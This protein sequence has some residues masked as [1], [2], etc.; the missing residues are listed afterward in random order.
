MAC[1]FRVNVNQVLILED[2]ST[3]VIQIA[4]KWK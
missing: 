3:M 2:F 4:A 1:V